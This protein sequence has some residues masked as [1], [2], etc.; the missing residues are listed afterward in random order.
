MTCILIAIPQNGLS[1]NSL[2]VSQ[3]KKAYGAY[4]QQQLWIQVPLKDGLEMNAESYGK[5]ARLIVLGIV[6]PSWKPFL[7]L[8]HV[9]NVATRMDMLQGSWNQVLQV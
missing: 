6:T 3:C 8:V 1:E 2:H 9:V 5:K 4:Y 7:I